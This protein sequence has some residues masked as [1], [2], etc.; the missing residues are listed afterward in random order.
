MKVKI[1]REEQ[2]KSTQTKESREKG[3]LLHNLHCSNEKES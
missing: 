3:L 2:Q 1:S